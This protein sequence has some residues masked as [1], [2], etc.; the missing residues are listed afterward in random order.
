MMLYV[1][2]RI[3]W[4]GVPHLRRVATLMS[5]LWA[6]SLLLAEAGLARLVWARLI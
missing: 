5:G 4:R 3:I 1:W 2:L 6:P